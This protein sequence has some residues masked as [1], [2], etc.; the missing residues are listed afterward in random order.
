MRPISGPS[1]HFSFRGS[2]VRSR[3]AAASSLPSF[4]LRTGLVRGP[5]T[6]QSHVPFTR[7]GVSSARSLPPHH[8]HQLV[9]GFDIDFLSW[10]KAGAAA[11][12]SAS[13]LDLAILAQMDKDMLK[14]QI[15]NMKFQATMERWPLSKSIAA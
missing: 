6:Q 14:K 15:E 2:S 8:H 1:C 9:V 7:Q 13:N 5:K 3:A 12:I 10:Y 4:P 11:P